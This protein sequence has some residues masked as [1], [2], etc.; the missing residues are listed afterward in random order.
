MAALQTRRPRAPD[1]CPDAHAVVDFWRA[2]ARNWFFGDARFD[3]LFRDR[4]LALHRAVVAGRCDDW[5]ATPEGALAL[6][7]LTDQ[8]P[9]N[10]FR[11]R[12]RMYASDPLARRHA[13]AALEAGH[14]DAVD[15]DLRLFFCLPFAHSETLSDQDL[16]VALHAGRLGDPWLSHARGH[17]DIIRRFGRFPHRNAILGR[18]STPDEAAFLQ[19]GGFSG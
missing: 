19:S 1:P 13:R 6:V 8:F 5:L 14:L 12:P 9:R 11:G 4:F 3:R 2:S 10:A 18:P 7:I 16:S 15:R 17:R